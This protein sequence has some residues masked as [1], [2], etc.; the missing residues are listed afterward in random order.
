MKWRRFAG[1]KYRPETAGARAV[2]W[3]G[4]L[5]NGVECYSESTWVLGELGISSKD[6]RRTSAGG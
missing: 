5:G 3:G 4:S 2:G 6:T 1:I